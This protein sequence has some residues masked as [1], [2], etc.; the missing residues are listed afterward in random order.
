MPSTVLSMDERLHALAGAQDGAFGVTQAAA[1]GVGPD[2]LRR[3]VRAG[4]LVRPRR[5][6][7]VDAGRWAVA[8]AD[9]RY[10][11]V[12]RS[13]AHSR[14]GD[15]VSHHAALALHGLPLWGHD[16]DRVDLLT[17]VGQAVR[18]PGIHVHPISDA[19][20]VAVGPLATAS[21]ARSVVRTALTMGRDC[22]VVA[23]DAALHRELV[24]REQLLGEVALVSPH[25]GRGRA[26]EA[27]LC[28][29]EKAESVGESRT[30]LVL[31]DLG[32]S[33][34]SQ[35]WIVDAAGVRVARVDFLVE[36]VVLEFDGRVKY[37]GALDQADRGPGEVSAA[38]AGED[39][40]RVVWLEKR[41]EDDIR[42]LG[43]PV[44]RVVWEELRRPGLIGV[45]VR[46]ARPRG[47]QQ[48]TG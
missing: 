37:L 3:A 27:V 12:V 48:P 42:R 40:A 31:V 43:H 24:T 7:Y 8:D 38:D 10:R 33:F 15:V 26:L 21:V 17:G 14:P 45:R 32:L 36:G 28:M 5:A 16:G 30:R 44:E 29:D 6:A 19:A 9:E 39:A 20:T 11:L 18:R 4:E 13:V 23:G 25:E 34:E 2:E 22:A 41:R 1:V 46:A 47:I 35:V